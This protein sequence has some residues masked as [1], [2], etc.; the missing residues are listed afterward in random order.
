M[1]DACDCDI[2]FMNT[3]ILMIYFY[4]SYSKEKGIY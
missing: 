2:Q 1:D 4:F 3:S